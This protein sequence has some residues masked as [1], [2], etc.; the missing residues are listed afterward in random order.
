MILPVVQLAFDCPYF[1]LKMNFECKWDSE[2]SNSSNTSIKIQVFIFHKCIHWHLM[3]LRGVP[4]ETKLCLRGELIIK[5]PFKPLVAIFIKLLL[6]MHQL[7]SEGSQMS[8]IHEKYEFCN[9]SAGIGVNYW[10]EKAT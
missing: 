5:F 4:V 7:A 2:W 8:V 1:F 10:W 3:S 9:L 6:Q